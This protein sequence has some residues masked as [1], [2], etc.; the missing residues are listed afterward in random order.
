[1]SIPSYHRKISHP[2]NQKQGLR[3]TRGLLPK[4]ILPQ[5]KKKEKKQ[6]FTLIH[7]QIKILKYI[8]DE[9]W[10]SIKDAIRWSHFGVN[11]FGRLKNI[12]EKPSLI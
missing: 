12:K 3:Y 4:I 10:I 7:K 8:I 6:L 9:R 2:L 1:M 11:K 5:E